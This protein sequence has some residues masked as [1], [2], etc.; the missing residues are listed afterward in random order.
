MFTT[1]PH[2]GKNT[3]IHIF[4]FHYSTSSHYH[5]HTNISHIAI[6]ITFLTI[7]FTF[8][9][10]HEVKLSTGSFSFA[11]IF[12][13]VAIHRLSFSHIT[14]SVKTIQLAQSSL[15]TPSHTSSFS[16]LVSPS[17]EIQ[18]IIPYAYILIILTIYHNAYVQFYH[19]NLTF[20]FI[21]HQ[22]HFL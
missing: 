13:W 1:N 19:H 15:N 20:L 5:F 14:Q 8:P 21:S 6:Y 12:S 4:P 16:S 10:G 3:N 18:H 9:F 11:I 7:T 17:C 22:F 2:N